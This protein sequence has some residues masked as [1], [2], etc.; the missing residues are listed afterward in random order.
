MRAP[1]A[2]I[3]L[4]YIEMTEMI[5]TYFR[6]AFVSGLTL[7]LPFLLYQLVM[8]I[9]PGLTSSERRYVYIFLPVVTLCFVGGAAFGYFVLLPPALNFLINFGSNIATP[10]I[11][12][13]NY[14]SLV[15]RLLFAL[16]ICF[17]TPLLIFFLA[18]IHVLTPERLSKFRKFTIVGAFIIGAVITP[19]FDP[20]NQSL[21]AV[22]L[23]ALYEIGVLLAK[24]AWRK[25]KK[26]TQAEQ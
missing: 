22:P 24:I 8:F 4:V 3:N 25:E 13:E 1:A 9:R 16:G 14:I 5:G 26:V 21:V 15:I 7:S 11:R 20:V 18:K 23:I 17:E 6:V 2:D 10:Q 12:V 19:T